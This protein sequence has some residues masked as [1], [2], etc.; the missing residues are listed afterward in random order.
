M[1]HS[2]KHSRRESAIITTD[3]KHSKRHSKKSSSAS[4]PAAAAATEKKHHRR[5]HHNKTKDAKISKPSAAAAAASSAYKHLH[6]KRI[7]SAYSKSSI[8]KSLGINSVYHKKKR[9]EMTAQE[10]IIHGAFS[11]P[12]LRRIAVQ[13]DAKKGTDEVRVRAREFST[14]FVDKA[15]REASDLARCARKKTIGLEHMMLALQNLYGIK[16]YGQ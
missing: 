12:I 7:P 6:A 16:V 1:G 13:A 14:I 9:D 4:E 10:R 8:T 11:D 5:H 2:D 15:I 3:E